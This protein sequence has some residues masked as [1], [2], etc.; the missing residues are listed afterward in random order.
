M[1]VEHGHKVWVVG[2]DQ[3][4]KFD[5]LVTNQMDVTI[6]AA[7]AD[8]IP[9]LFADPVAKVIGAAHAG[10]RGT[11][12]RVAA[13]VVRAMVDEFGSRPEN[14]RVAMGPSLQ[15]GCFSLPPEEAKLF[16]DIHP[17]CAA[18]NLARVYHRIDDVTD[19]HSKGKQSYG[20]ADLKETLTPA[21]G[22]S[23]KHETRNVGS[24]LTEIESALRQGNSVHVSRS[25]SME[26]ERVPVKRGLNPSAGQVGSTLIGIQEKQN[27][28]DDS[29]PATITVTSKHRN[30]VHVNLQL[31]NR[32][33]LE[34]EGIK[35]E[36]IDESTAVCTRCNPQLYYSFERDGFPFGNQIGFICM[37]S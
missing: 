10:W 2:K 4:N 12:E 25:T 1:K 14:I 36:H 17:S 30:G 5:A 19:T 21:N 8:C 18:T 27:L 20:Q 3:P 22:I 33:V 29:G 26:S 23:E 6:A 35:P 34:R 31:A 9:L 37:P 24:T 16:S 11:V 28:V 7:G 13:C 32:F 15:M